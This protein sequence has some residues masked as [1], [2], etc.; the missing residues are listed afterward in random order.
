MSIDTQSYDLE[1]YKHAL[2]TYIQTRGK[3]PICKKGTIEKE[4]TKEGYFR[5]E[6]SNCH[7]VLEIGPPTY[8]NIYTFLQQKKEEIDQQRNKLYQ[9]YISTTQHSKSNK[10]EYERIQEQIQTEYNT[11]TETRSMIEQQKESM[12]RMLK[13]IDTDRITL[14]TNGSLRASYFQQL[15]QP[16]IPTKTKLEMIQIYKKEA[17]LS[18]QR[19]QSVAKQLSLSAH[20]VDCWCK[21]F[22][23]ICSYKKM[24]LAV[25]SIVAQ[26]QQTHD[27]IKKRYQLF[28]TSPPVIH[29]KKGD[30]GGS[31]L[32]H[33]HVSLPVDVDE[34]VR[35]ISVGAPKKGGG[36]VVNEEDTK[37]IVSK[38]ST[39]VPEY[40]SISIP[41]TKKALAGWME[42]NKLEPIPNKRGGFKKK[43]K[44]DTDSLSSITD[45]SMD[46]DS[47]LSNEE[48]EEDS[49]V[50]EMVDMNIV[51]TKDEKMKDSIIKPN[52]Q[53]KN[54][55]K[56]GE[57]KVKL[58]SMDTL[59]ALSIVNP[60][61]PKKRTS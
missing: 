23:V 53:Q 39:Y 55:Q 17:P 59:D 26:Y 47:L 37:S 25:E 22:E 46:T 14:Y 44:K 11:F 27:Q 38:A 57:K 18:K 9:L 28:V 33:E 35:Q 8:T 40:K 50:E 45:S 13:Q 49:I 43:K 16:K 1:S 12:D 10:E 60:T 41:M 34:D 58:P 54:V 6:C 7:Y 61:H 15:E 32:S 31:L 4:R 21:W 19:I 5:L 48:E 29:E 56:K 24:E 3:C 30:V 52:V 42:E 36:S 20:D 2:L 51:K